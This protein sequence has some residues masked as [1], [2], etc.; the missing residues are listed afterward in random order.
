MV[1]KEQ[2]KSSIIAGI[3]F[4]ILGNPTTYK[5]VAKVVP[6]VVVDGRVSTFGLA[7]HAFIFAAITYGIM[8]MKQ[9]YNM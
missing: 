7:F 1:Q 5:Y 4:F 3:L 2:I 8:V 9:K 6:N